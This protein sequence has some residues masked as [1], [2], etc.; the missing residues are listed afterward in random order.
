M[1][2][3]TIPTRVEGSVV[4]PKEQQK[5]EK[6]IKGK[7]ELA[8]SVAEQSGT[9][10]DW[11][12][13]RDE[14]G[15]PFLGDRPPPL[16]K[17]K[18]MAKDPMLRFG[19]HYITTPHVRAQYHMDARDKDG[20]NAQI[21]G[22]MD[23]LW[24]PIHP[25]FMMQ[26]L[27]SIRWGNQP[28]AKRFATGNPGGVYQDTTEQDPAKQMKPV[29]DEGNVDPIILKTFV[30]LDPQRCQ[31]LFDDSTGEF[32]GIQYEV[33][34]A[35]RKRNLGFGGAGSNDNFR[36]IDVYHSLWIT[37]NRAD[38]FGSIYGFPRLGL[39][40]RYWWS[41]WYCWAMI[42]RAIERMAIPPLIA[43]HPEGD[44]EDPD[45]PSATLPYSEIALNTAEQLRA[46]AI[47]AVPSTLAAAGLDERGT[48]Q[49]EWEFKFLE[50]VNA[51]IEQMIAF[52]QYCDVMK[53]RSIWIP[54]SVLTQ[55][56]GGSAQRNIVSQMTETFIESQAN[57]A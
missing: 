11:R 14:L 49:R 1:P 22:F 8:P 6:S 26:A 16:R 27:L 56:E 40:Y 47:A 35:D 51:P 17:L 42:D 30:P 33:P 57:L 3:N 21:A 39:A 25:S 46:N 52:T 13:I 28:M 18:E 53:L 7:K 19:M 24:R 45:D 50:T 43:Y 41:H 34:A 36:E 5:I 12:K 15:Q 32:D 48:Q 31:P 23:S 9:F 38:E 10:V 37:H 2:D 29:W 20:P 44:Y 4:D 55:G 54:E